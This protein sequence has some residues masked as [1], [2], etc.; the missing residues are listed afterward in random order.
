MNCAKCLGIVTDSDL[1]WKSHID[2]LFKKLL[3]FTVIFTNYAQELDLM[4]WR[5]CI[6]LLCIL[7]YYMEL[8]CM[9]ILVS[10]TLRTLLFSIINCCIDQNC[11]ARTCTVELF[12]RYSTL[13]LPLLHKYNVLCFVHKCFYNSL[14]M[15][16]VVMITFNWT[17]PSTFMILG[18]L[19]GYICTPSI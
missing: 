13:P 3:K 1:S 2:Y 17:M 19:T 15:P 11:P 6:L 9:L 14:A 16:N 7:S 12:K 8:K 10:L 18:P 5:C 4:F